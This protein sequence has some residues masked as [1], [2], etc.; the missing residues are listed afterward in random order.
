[1]TPQELLRAVG[2]R[3]RLHRAASAVL[4]HGWW[5]VLGCVALVASARLLP[6]RAV[7]AVGVALPAVLLG[8][9]AVWRATRPVPDA[10]AAQVAD[11]ALGSRDALSAYVEFGDG[12]GGHFS[13]R[14]AT[15]A[16]GVAE[17]ADPREAAPRPP[18]P[19][20]RAGVLSVGVLAAVTLVLVENP[21]DVAREER[22]AADAAV[23]EVVED[24]RDA[25]EQAG[26]DSE[27]G[28]H[29]TALADRLEELSPEEALRELARAEA[30]LNRRAGDDLGTARAA[31]DGLEASLQ[32][33]PL[34]GAEA[35]EP[36]AA[37]LDSAADALAAM[38]PQERATL[39]QRL[40]DL[41]ATQVAGA[42]ALAAA[43]SEAAD[44]VAAGDPGAADALRGAADAQRARAAE[45][46]DRA[47]AAA[48]AAAAGAARSSLSSALDPSRASGPA[49]SA[50]GR[51]GRG[52]GNGK[53]E[54]DGKGEG[55]GSGEGE[56]S[57]QGQGQGQGQ[58][59]GGGGASGQVGAGQ[60]GGTGAG[61]G[62]QGDIGN[63]GGDPTRSEE[64]PAARS[65]VFAPDPRGRR[66]GDGPLT[67]SGGDLS[68]REGPAD[69]TS[70]RG[71]ARL[72]VAEAVRRYRD[73][74][75]R[76]IDQP[77]L[78]PARRDL[79]SGY[80]D[81]LSRATAGG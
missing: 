42:L 36:A 37:Q 55:S 64:E 65:E 72:P 41:A 77:G 12:Q 38:S 57:G 28:R 53:G 6:W 15:R 21:Q 4:D 47:A 17:G 26:V 31:A 8:A 62:G 9:Y 39:A 61:R 2:R 66:G 52:E 7:E 70:E 30:E 18:V 40:E 78:P 56:G 74:A 59:R 45:V 5:A 44:A 48:A 16:R 68:G 19:R 23:A 71:A 50:A 29:L 58:G 35:S 10:L 25:A 81:R 20:W 24:L 3:V 1:M 13:E 54:G 76:A 33:R 80:F 60:R 73:Q 63:G 43:L 46:A 11:R 14:I 22:R 69:A 49:E 32:A 34:P 75:A 79:I 27:Q 51:S 67:G